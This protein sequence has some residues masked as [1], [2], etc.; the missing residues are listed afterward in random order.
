MGNSNQKKICF[1]STGTI[2]CLFQILLLLA[3]AGA[4]NLASAETWYVSTLGYDSNGGTGW[5]DTFATIQRG[6]D[7]A[8][9]GD[10]VI[11]ADGTYTGSGNK[12]IILGDEEVEVRSVN[13]PNSCIIDL[14]NDGKGFELY[15]A[16]IGSVI[17]GFTIM[18]GHPTS[19]LSY[20]VGIKCY[21]CRTTIR[22][23]IIKNNSGVQWGAGI[24]V[25]GSIAQPVIVNSIFEDNN[26]SHAG[27]AV[28]VYQTSATFTN[29][30]F[31]SNIS[32]LSV[33]ATPTT[34]SF[35]NCIFWNN[36]PGTISGNVTYSDVEGGYTGTGNIDIDPEFV[37]PDNGDFRLSSASDCIDAGNNLTTGIPNQDIEGKPRFIDG[38]GDLSAMVDMG[39]YEYGKIC[40]YDYLTDQD[41]DGSDLA[42]Y[43]NDTGVIKELSLLAEEYGRIDCPVY[44]YMP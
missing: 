12:N 25:R 44:A 32:F 13:G 38:D 43:I 5:G 6:I 36:D 39:T 15:L 2:V 19:S 40:E 34:T 17:D 28:S 8:I 11:V 29:C 42:E 31:I 23:C 1:T 7:E 9:N 14:E 30:T 10:T 33:V 37:D 26:S 20:G 27:S 22:N 3:V 16:P 18:N 35:T 24:D 21:N 4:L 41:T